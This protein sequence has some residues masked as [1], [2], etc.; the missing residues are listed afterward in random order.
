MRRL[1]EWLDVSHIVSGTAHIA[2]GLFCLTVVTGTLVNSAI[3]VQAK[4]QLVAGGASALTASAEG[5]R[6][7]VAVSVG[8]EQDST[9]TADIIPASAVADAPASVMVPAV[10]RS[11]D[12]DALLMRGAVTAKPVLKI[13]LND[14][15]RERRCLV[16]GIYYEARGENAK[17]QLAVAEV[18]LN[19]VLSGRY[20][21]SICGVVFQGASSGR[22]QFS[23]ACGN[24]MKHPRN[25]VAWRKAQRL[26]HYVLSGQVNKSIIGTATYYH[27]TYVSPYWAPHMVEVAKIG[28]HVFY[29]SNADGLS[30]PE[31]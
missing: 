3:S 6:D 11:T 5:G 15:E 4:P 8:N 13:K 19:R 20:P 24:S 17:G 25:K 7:V 26:A 10:F 23:F 16:E 27:A 9:T 21:S 28:Q 12:G 2:V 14:L 18:V 29:R 30:D 22:C 31:S 1:F